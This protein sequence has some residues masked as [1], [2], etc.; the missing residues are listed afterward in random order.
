MKAMAITMATMMRGRMS[1]DS[2]PWRDNLSRAARSILDDRSVK[3]FWPFI[4][5]FARD[6]DI[7]PEVFTIFLVNSYFRLSIVAT[8]NSKALCLENAHAAVAIELDREHCFFSLLLLIEI[9]LFDRMDCWAKSH[10]QKPNGGATG[11]NALAALSYLYAAFWWPQMC[12]N[13]YRETLT[14]F[15]RPSPIWF[16]ATSPSS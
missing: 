2:R 12:G 9:P 7:P 10:T 14:A 1:G 3:H 5:V 11:L 4:G 15:D 13:G 8:E 16:I 6:A